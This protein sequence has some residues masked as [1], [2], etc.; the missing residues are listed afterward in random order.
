MKHLVFVLT[1]HQ[2]HTGPDVGGVRST[3]NDAQRQ[4]IA[5]S[6]NSASLNVL[7]V[8]S[9]TAGLFLDIAGVDCEC[10][11]DVVRL[12]DVILGAANARFSNSCV[13]IRLKWH[14]VFHGGLTVDPLRV[15]K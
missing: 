6:L 14:S 11:G 8:G 3:R 7:L 12:P 9:L 4:L 13:D 2:V 10:S 1:A 5:L 15:F